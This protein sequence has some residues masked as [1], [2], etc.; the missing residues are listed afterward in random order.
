MID[1]R[2]EQKDERV[3]VQTTATTRCVKEKKEESGEEWEGGQVNFQDGAVFRAWKPMQERCRTHHRKRKTARTRTGAGVSGP[4]RR[5]QVHRLFCCRKKIG[6][7]D[8][9]ATGV[10]LE[11]QTQAQCNSLVS[12][13]LEE[14]H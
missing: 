4:A 3:T 11:A 12:F 2:K 9:G 13:L 7:S 5:S 6:Q 1:A 8:L 10:K 14:L